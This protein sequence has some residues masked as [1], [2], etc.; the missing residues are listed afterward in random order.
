MKISE[1][2]IDS[3]YD[4]IPGEIDYLVDYDDY[5]EELIVSDAYKLETGNEF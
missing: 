3:Y 5:G 4:F 1:N 2:D